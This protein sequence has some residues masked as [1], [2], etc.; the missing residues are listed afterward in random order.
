MGIHLK[1]SSRQLAHLSFGIIGA[2]AGGR[3]GER[4]F[5]H[6]LLQPQHLSVGGVGLGGF[7]S[8]A[9]ALRTAVAVHTG[10]VS[11]GCLG[12]TSRGPGEPKVVRCCEHRRAGLEGRDPAANFV[13]RMQ[14]LKLHAYGWRGG[15]ASRSASDFAGQPV[16]LQSCHSTQ[17]R[18]PHQSE[19]CRWAGRT[20]TKRLQDAAAVA[21]GGTLGR[22]RRQLALLHRPLGLVPPPHV[23]LPVQQLRALR[24]GFASHQ[25]VQTGVQQ[26]CGSA[27]LTALL[28]SLRD[29]EIW[30]YCRVA[31]GWPLSWVSQC[32]TT[33][34]CTKTTCAG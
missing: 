9:A 15:V 2:V 19:Q 26:C 17:V 14:L 8:C 20:Y 23:G 18:F 11:A 31:L 32:Q 10:R 12:A 30:I 28:G 4:V 7:S 33:C 21:H 34:S 3:G 1:A 5:H 16:V 6:H 24:K 25:S 13:F 29:T 22:S 27:R